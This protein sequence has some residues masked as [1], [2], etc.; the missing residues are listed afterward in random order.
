MSD[1]IEKGYTR[2][3]LARVIIEAA[4]PLAVGSGEESILSDALVA[5]DVNG[6]PYIPGTA[7]AGVLRHMMEEWVK[8]NGDPELSESVK[9]IFGYH[10]KDGGRGS[11]IIFS[12]AKIL[13]HEGIPVDGLDWR[14]VS[15]DPLLSYYQDLPVRQHVRMTDKGAAQKRGKFD[16]QVVFTGTRFCFEI[17]ML[18][19]GG[20][21]DIFQ[22]I[23]RQLTDKNFRIGSGTR[24]G[25]GAVRIVDLKT[26]SLNLQDKE[27]LERYIS[28]SSSLASDFWKNVES[29]E[30]KAPVAHD[31]VDYTLTLTPD[32]FFIFSSGFGDSEADMTPVK[33]EKVIWENGKGKMKENLVLIPAS[34][35]KGAISHRTAFHWNR[36]NNMFSDLRDTKTPLPVGPLNDA[37]R[38]LF[39]SDGS[40]GETPDSPEKDTDSKEK[41]RDNDITKGNVIFSDVILDAHFEE[42]LLNHL[43]VD[44]FSGS[45]WSGALFSER[46]V[47]GNGSA[48]KLSIQVNKRDL[49]NAYSTLKDIVN[50]AKLDEKDF[51]E[52]VLGAFEKALN[53]I[54]TGLLPLGGGVN[55]GHGIFTGKLEKIDYENR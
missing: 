9:T 30:T 54:C 52:K 51:I 18:S 23:L 4:T 48:L 27:D 22:M 38:L 12:E 47:S 3:F 39:G 41:D 16:C 7:V 45:A 10:D 14:A 5:T 53:D 31:T 1:N 37:V 42:K 13:N 8:D 25:Y 21:E 20:N 32:T 24:K 6:L 34:S 2:R 44:R 43:A 26:L 46:V 29:T 55:R 36:I 17:E 50:P 11:E 15:T 40:A 35:V 28:K 19:E 33:A 49:R